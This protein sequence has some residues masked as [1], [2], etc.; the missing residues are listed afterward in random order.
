LR[1]TI[2]WVVGSIVLLFIMLII[3]YISHCH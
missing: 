2:T 1:R 3:S